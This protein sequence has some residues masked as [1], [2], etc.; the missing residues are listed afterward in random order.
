MNDLIY[1]LADITFWLSGRWILYSQNSHEVPIAAVS[2]HPPHP[3]PRSYVPD[4]EVT[5]FTCHDLNFKFSKNTRSSPCFYTLA[6]KLI[7]FIQL[8]I[9]MQCRCK[10]LF[11]HLDNWLY[12]SNRPSRAMF[13]ISNLLFFNFFKKIFTMDLESCTKMS[14]VQWWKPFSKWMLRRG[15]IVKK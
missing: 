11:T 2:H 14:G 4:H 8:L 7:L 15:I 3:K 9:S 10:Y 6:R 5:C 1:N 13:Q 12:A